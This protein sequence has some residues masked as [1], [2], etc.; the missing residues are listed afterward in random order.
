MSE[1]SEGVIISFDDLE[2]GGEKENG[3]SYSLS[4]FTDKE[5]H[6]LLKVSLDHENYEQAEEYRQ[7]LERRNGATHQ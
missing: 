1:D 3:Y 4:R 7:E 6:Q 2:S 5:L